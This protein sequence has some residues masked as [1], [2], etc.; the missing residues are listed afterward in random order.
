MSEK[1]HMSPVDCF[2]GSAFRKSYI[3]TDQ[4]KEEVHN[5]S[6]DDLLIVHPVVDGRLKD[7]GRS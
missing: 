5:V 2:D 6:T 1:E 4:R 7:E 3:A